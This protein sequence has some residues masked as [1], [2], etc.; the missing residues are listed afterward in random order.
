MGAQGPRR[1][2]GQSGRVRHRPRLRL[3]PVGGFDERFSSVGEDVDCAG[4]CG[5]R[6]SASATSR[7]PPS[8]TAGST[9]RPG[10]GRGSASTCS[11]AMRLF[12][13]FKNLGSEHLETALA[14]ATL[15]DM[16]EATSER[17]DVALVVIGRMKPL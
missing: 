5:W 7:A 9:R 6:A 8:A 16:L 3:K 12:C 17:I 13:L 15:A 10:W 14:F 2:V 4:A 11:S 1:A